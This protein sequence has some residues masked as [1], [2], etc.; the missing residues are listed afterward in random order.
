[1]KH[2]FLQITNQHRGN[3]MNDLS[4]LII[5]FVLGI[6]TN[7]LVWW[8][9]FHL[10]IPAIRFSDSI[11]KKPLEHTSQDKSGQ[12]YRVKI[13]N[14]GVRAIIDVEIYACLKVKASGILPKNNWD[15]T[16]IALDYEGNT[17]YQIPRMISISYL[18]RFLEYI[19]DKPLLKKLVKKAIPEWKG[20]RMSPIIQLHL[21]VTDD[22]KTN[23][24]Y[25]DEIRQKAKKKELLLED[26]LCL[27]SDAFLEINL[28][29]YD[30][31]SGSRKLFVSKRYRLQDIKLGK[32]RCSGMDVVA[33]DAEI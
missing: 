26:L 6:A 31:F 14:L 8:V 24:M 3:A 30:E 15:S 23:L 1:M 5:S 19:D 2:S 17:V 25:P 9:L 28:F 16:K 32:F 33:E 20:H 18:T 27:G 13:R 12:R 22:F 7:F 4:G 11:C 29:G 10:F 21:N